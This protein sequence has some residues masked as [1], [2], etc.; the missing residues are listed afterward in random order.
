[1]VV[2]CYWC[3]FW[4]RRRSVF[5][6][7]SSFAMGHLLSYIEEVHVDCL[8]CISIYPKDCAVVLLVGIDVFRRNS[9]FA[10]S[11]KAINGNDVMLHE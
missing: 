8:K 1:M 5:G 3:G 6:G 7:V 11:A 4:A 2:A 10:Y 9:S